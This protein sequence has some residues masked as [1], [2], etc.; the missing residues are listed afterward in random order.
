MMTYEERLN[1]LID[2]TKEDGITDANASLIFSV[3]CDCA[4]DYHEGSNVI[5]SNN[6]DLYFTKQKEF[7]QSEL[8]TEFERQE[9]ER[10]ESLDLRMKA[11]TE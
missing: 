8:D 11:F 10:K 6:L 5:S 2:S 1:I 4:T 9:R 7:R 3:I